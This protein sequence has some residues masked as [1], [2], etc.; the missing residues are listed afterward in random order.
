MDFEY[1]RKKIK[2]EK[3]CNDNWFILGID[4]GT[5][6]TVV[7]YWNEKKGKPIT[8]DMSDG[9]GKIP[10]PSVVQY[11]HANDEWVVGYEA[12]NT[13]KIYDETTI[14]SIKRKMGTSE[15]VVFNGNS[16]TPQQ[17]TAK[18]LNKIIEACYK[19][20]PNAEI[21]GVVITVPYT[22]D[23][24]A[25]R[26]TIESCEI[27]GIK[28]KVV[29]LIEEPKAAALAYTLK[30]NFEKDERVL[31]F[32][33]G[34]GTLDLTLFEVT[35]SDVNNLKLNVV[36]EGGKAFHGGDN[37]D[38]ILMNEAFKLIKQKVGKAK[39]EINKEHRVDMFLKTVDGKER[40]SKL[41][42][43]KIPYTFCVPPF[44]Q[45]LTKDE[46][47]N[48]VFD[49]I[50]ETR[51]IILQC[52]KYTHDGE[53]LPNMVHKII[54]LGGSSKNTWVLDLIVDIFKEE[55]KIYASE[56]P[57]LD[58]SIGAT[59][60]CAMKMGLINDKNVTSTRKEVNFEATIPHDIGLIVKRGSKKKFVPLIH[61]G[62]PYKLAK[63]SK[64]FTLTGNTEEDM[65]TFNMEFYERINVNDESK[66]CKLLGYVS[67]N[68]LPKRP[69]GK[70]K[71]KIT[72]IVSEENGLLY[73]EVEDL[74]FKEEYEP[75]GYK[76]KFEPNA[77]NKTVIK[78]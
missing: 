25:K 29:A 51:K 22:F 23:N 16:F 76:E 78:G 21:A 6:N 72:L 13:L 8:I 10:M 11:R 1:Y 74:G 30:N 67:F 60:F 7:T 17:I 77:L 34:G 58:I 14:R 31:V 70:T 69:S 28:E 32:D 42:K 54:L 68:N 40:L 43:T 73:G 64:V 39:T 57:E 19:I 75:S 44:V 53:V 9:F 56:K 2:E 15:K 45:C 65:S 63:K 20:N 4:L 26:A 61:R 71:L 33:F 49:F 12:Y 46:Y 50:Q 48:L 52:L 41:H 18:I 27:A 36:S 3:K 55:E 38:D 59:Y 37:I 47:E 62:T 5:T 66:D 35:K 24:N